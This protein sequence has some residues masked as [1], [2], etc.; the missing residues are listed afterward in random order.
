MKNTIEIS[1]LGM[2]IGLYNPYY[3][4]FGGG[5][6][7][8][9]TLASA[10]SKAHT[11]ELFWDDP[12]ILSQSEKRFHLNLS[13][14]RVVPNIF[15]TNNFFSKMAASSQY[16][17]IF[18]ITDGS[19]PTSLAKHNILHFQV[20][21]PRVSVN[22]FKLRRFDYIVCNSLY[23]QSHIDQ[24][25]AKHSRVIYPP[26]VP[27]SVPKHT[28]KE[29]L[30]LSVGRFT[31]VAEVKKQSVMIDAFLGMESRVPGWKLV[32]AG[33]LL[34]S[35]KEYFSSLEKKTAGH[36]ISLIA[37]VEHSQ[38]YDLYGRA[39]LYWHAAGFGQSDPRF[40]EHFGISTVEA[41]SAGAVPVVYKG[42]GQTEIVTHKEN[43]LYWVTV[44]ELIEQT[45]GVIADKKEYIRLQESALKTWEKFS[46]DAFI[47][48]FERLIAAFHHTSV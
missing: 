44:D 10:W 26:V 39:S 1:L 16:D 22:P 28:H 21:F 34:P 46:K 32:L 17:L 3:D 33:G 45:L 12:T 15:S 4:G 42:G 5:E 2:R 14:V 37:N 13:R 25:I 27:V 7:Y 20:P 6:R 11:V 19:V 9:L 41:M 18:F 8:T 31:P 47:V 35:D 40:M 38:L 36:R 23:T 29:K 43:G 48:G 30:I 24:R